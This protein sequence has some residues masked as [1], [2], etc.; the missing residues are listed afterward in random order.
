MKSFKRYKALLYIVLALGVAGIAW[1][2]R[3]RAVT[4]LSIDYGEDDYLRAGQQYAALIRSGDWTGFTQTNYRPEHPPLAKMIYGASLLTTPEKPLL[5]DLSSSEGPNQYIPRTI[6]KTGRM[7]SALFGTLAAFLLALVNPLAGLF[8]SIQTTTIKYTSEVM[9]EAVPALF[10]FASV[11]CYVQAKRKISDSH[12]PTRINSWQIF[13]AIFLGL[14]AASKY[15]YC[16][17][18][19]A[20]LIDWFVHSRENESTRRFFLH[21][22][23]W[24]L[25][26]IVVFFAADP[27]LWPSP[28][29]R[30]ES[31]VLF[32][33][34]YSTGTH[35]QEAGFPI[36]QPFIWMSKSVPWQGDRPAFM[37]ALDALLFLLAVLGISRLWRK[38]R[39][40]VI[41][42]GVATVFLLLW[43][44]KWPQYILILTVPLSLAA[45]EG[46]VA[47][48][49]QPVRQ[50]LSQ[51][52]DRKSRKAS[53]PLKE[54]RQAMPWLL[55][56]LL[57]FAILTLVPLVFQFGISLT[58]FNTASI[59]DGLHG[60]LWQAILGG[61]TGKLPIT[62][63]RG[64][65]QQVSYL[66]LQAYPYV[67]ESIVGGDL[68]FT[69]MMWTVL[70]VFFQTALGLGIALL[71]WQR[72]AL[73]RKFWQAFFILPWAIP[74]FIGALLWANV[75]R[76]EW[77]WL[78]LA[79]QKFG[80]KFPF[81]FLNNWDNS[82][83]L[84][85]VLLIPAVWYG[86]PFM[87]LAAR[88]GLKMIP[89]D[90]FDAAAID[91]ANAI[92]TFS[93]V[94]WPL[95]QPLIIPAIIVRSIFAF[96][97]FYLFQAFFGPR[98]IGTLANI[99]YNVFYSGQ[100]FASAVINVIA[101]ALLVGFVWLFNHWSKASEGVAYA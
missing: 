12:T 57:A 42:L 79:V 1:A 88:A 18:G 8:L 2:L 14:T 66:G 99:S 64:P 89:T 77:G 11:L 41:W 93:F 39:L 97:Q 84:L 94:T 3:W 51:G 28:V 26:A 43:Q 35:V 75:L 40:Y 32:N 86:F 65:S 22:G 67:M 91:G 5:P 48:V 54:L 80:P 24:G 87:M 68:L 70:S 4:T 6:L 49:F 74:E 20:I 16:V 69:N 23:L 55:P 34:G 7:V 100:F 60:G 96:N 17:V 21:A 59:R 46:F 72:G 63:S 29:A 78:A 15:I 45:A 9:L 73:F 95:L 47:L 37:I 10:S 56:G 52:R 71:L 38:E 44:T 30:L 82:N 33:A 13:S 61:L 27:F 31:S 98:D 19:I 36:W 85:L 81:A 83:V 76:P 62:F 58:S 25:I 101:V 92:E 50:W 53:A 90:V